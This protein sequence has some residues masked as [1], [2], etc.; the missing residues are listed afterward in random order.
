MMS[1]KKNQEKNVLIR[2]I[3][4]TSRCLSRYHKPKMINIRVDIDAAKRLSRMNLCSSA[5][6]DTH[7]P[8]YQNYGNGLCL[9]LSSSLSFDRIHFSYNFVKTTTF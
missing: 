8:Y 3:E 4:D 6:R 9:F 7:P 5:Q 2:V 1:T